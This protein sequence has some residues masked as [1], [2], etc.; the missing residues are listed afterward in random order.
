[1][2]R[3]SPVQVVDPRVTMETSVLLMMSSSSCVLVQPGPELISLWL[4]T[5]SDAEL[6]IGKF[7]DIKDALMMED[8]ERGR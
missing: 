5:D 8:S 7:A 1:M 3:K 4:L 6:V 2:N